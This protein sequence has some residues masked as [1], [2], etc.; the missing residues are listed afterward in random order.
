MTLKDKTGELMVRLVREFPSE[1]I[2]G[3]QLFV[4]SAFVE[5]AEAAKAEE[6]QKERERLFSLL[7]PGISHF[8]DS[9]TSDYKNGYNDMLA[10]AKNLLTTPQSK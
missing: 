8:Y 5:I 10:T 7:P 4:L 2:D 3:L 6:R 1:N 9:H